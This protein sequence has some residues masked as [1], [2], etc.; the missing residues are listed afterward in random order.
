MEKHLKQAV[1]S[2]KETEKDIQPI[3]SIDAEIIIEIREALKKLDQ[4]DLKAILAEWKNLKDEKIRDMLID[5]NINFTP[6]EEKE[7]KGNDYS[8]DFI[9]FEDKSL[10][11]R[12]ILSIGRSQKYNYEEGMFTYQITINENVSDKTHFFNLT[13][14]YKSKED[15]DNKYNELHELL[16]ETNTINFY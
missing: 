1:N 6:E 8:R 16:S 13:F 9:L 2:F 7:E 10:E 12:Y 11:I 4:N 15:R 3:S 14:P 5:W